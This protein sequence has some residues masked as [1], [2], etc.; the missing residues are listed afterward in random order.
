MLYLILGSKQ[1]IKVTYHSVLP[2]YLKLT[3]IHYQFGVQYPKGRFHR[4]VSAHT[5]ES[6]LNFAFKAHLFDFMYIK[7]KLAIRFFKVERKISDSKLLLSIVTKF[8]VLTM[9]DN[10]ILMST[11]ENHTYQ[12][13]FNVILFI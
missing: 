13:G 1:T 12:C 5:S 4:R 7:Q 3:D 2:V 8:V 9:S 10:M 6:S 11:W